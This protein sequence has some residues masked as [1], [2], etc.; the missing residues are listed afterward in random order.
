MRGRLHTW[1]DEITS[2]LWFIPSIFIVLAIVIS[3]G[4]I[5]IDA[6]LAAQASPLIP[7]IFSGTA[8]AARTVL[9]VIAGSLITVISIAISL[10]IVALVQASAQ[11]TPRVLRQ[12]TASRPNQVVLGAYAAT[13]IYALLVLRA[14]RSAEQTDSGTA[15]QAS[16]VPALSVTVA[17]GLA[18]I[19]VG[20]LI[21]FIH[22]IA[23]SL[24][25]SR[26]LDRIRHEFVA[27]LDHLYPADDRGGDPDHHAVAHHVEEQYAAPIQIIRSEQAGFLRHIDQDALVAATHGTTDWLWVRPPI[28]TFVAYGGILAE[29]AG[30]VPANDDLTGRIRAACILAPERTTSQDI[31]FAIRQIVDIGLRAL[32]PGINDMT[33]AEYALW[34]L[35]DMLGRLAIR[36]FPPEEQ[37]AADGVTRLRVSRP[38]WEVFVATAF[39]QLR[40]A[41]QADVHVTQTLLEVLTDLVARIPVDRRG[42]VHHQLSEIRHALNQASWSPADSVAL[43]TQANA[44]AQV[45]AGAAAYGTT[46]RG[47]SVGRTEGS[48][49]SR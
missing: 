27:Q 22:H 13:F 17:L 21:F 35:S 3:T 28:G 31:L 26:I 12:F 47:T 2:S 42:A 25:I 38:S 34:H 4:L 37:R 40:R 9:S 48:P 36:P 29:Y 46:S 20:L 32:S 24:Q 39:D 30:T 14:V 11:W 41:G 5:E 16:F 15:I 7:W 23:Q 44:L 43:Q 8:D 1:W 49:W 19:C 45:L 18:L 10:T 6:W 33:T